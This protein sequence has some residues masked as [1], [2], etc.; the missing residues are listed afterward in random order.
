M[1]REILSESDRKTVINR[2]QRKITIQDPMYQS[3]GKIEKDKGKWKNKNQ[4]SMYPTN[5]KSKQVK[6]RM[7][8]TTQDSMYQSEENL[9]K[10]KS[11][12]EDTNLD[13]IDKLNYLDK[14]PT[15]DHQKGSDNVM[16]KIHNAKTVMKKLEAKKVVSLEEVLNSQK[17]NRLNLRGM[18]EVE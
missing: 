10:D 12:K 13:V 7:K 8:N 14:F 17:N 9:E 15:Y 18:P 5:E 6:T 4:E 11:R 3:R 1:L 2:N 16:E